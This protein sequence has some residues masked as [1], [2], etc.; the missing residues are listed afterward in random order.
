M[1]MTTA[2]LAASA[3]S[4]IDWLDTPEGQEWAS[5][6]GRPVQSARRRD[7]G[8]ITMAQVLPLPV[9]LAHSGTVDPAHD[10]CGRPPLRRGLTPGCAAGYR[11]AERLC[12]S[13]GH[14]PEACDCTCCW[15]GEG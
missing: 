6:R 13:C 14:C 1:T 15:P 2:I 8:Q 3:Q 4:V 12:G 11:M 9:G 10:P 5:K 7:E